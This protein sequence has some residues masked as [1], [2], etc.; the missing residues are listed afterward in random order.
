MAD[1]DE[2]YCLFLLFLL[3]PSVPLSFGPLRVAGCLFCGSF[4]FR[5]L[6]LSTMPS[7][8]PVCI[9]IDAII[10]KFQRR[11]LSAES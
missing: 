10:Y 8:D 11:R 9:F 6:N 2:C 5:K 4:H 3:L 1:R 7:I